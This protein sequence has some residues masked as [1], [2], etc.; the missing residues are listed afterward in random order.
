MS[1]LCVCVFF[2]CWACK[3][4]KIQKRH[5]ALESFL[6]QSAGILNTLHTY[7]TH[8]PKTVHIH[9]CM[10]MHIHSANPNLTTY[11]HTKLHTHT[12]T[13]DANYYN[14]RPPPH[15]HT[16]TH[17]L[18]IH[19]YIVH[20]FF[21]ASMCWRRQTERALERRRKGGREGREGGRSVSL[22]KRESSDLNSSVW[23]WNQ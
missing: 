10:Y 4:L 18:Y 1:R 20:V 9:Y 17:I 2:F 11:T 13:R 19:T 15:T 3:Q 21:K 8:I 23:I 12:H 5:A 7:A 14:H 6:L 16:Y 22:E